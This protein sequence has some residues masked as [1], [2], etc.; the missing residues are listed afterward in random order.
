MRFRQSIPVRYADTDA[1]GHVFFANYLTYFDEAVTG[2]CEAIGFGYEDLL[3][4]GVDFVYADAR[5]SWTGSVRFGDALSVG[6]AFTKLG[7]SSITADFEVQANGKVVAN[8]RCVIV[9][10]GGEPRASRP[11]PDGLRAAVAAYES[12]TA[13]RRSG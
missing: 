1:Q 13:T 7:G 9:C 8:G 6:C 3:A 11:I 4:A 10:T 12:A 2:Y 5:C